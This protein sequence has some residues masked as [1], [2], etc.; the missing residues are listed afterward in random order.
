MKKLSL[1]AATLM[2]FAVA[3][4]QATRA[5]TMNFGDAVALW[6]NACKADVTTK[7]KGIRVGGNRLGQCIQS[8]ASQRCKE[9]TALFNANMEA[10]FQAQKD[11]PR[12]CASSVKRLCSNFKPGSAR[13]LRCMMRPANFRAANVPCKNAL[14]NA[15]WLDEISIRRN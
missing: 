5:E 12:L 13:V 1:F 9:A 15:G 6:A 4:L 11:A 8:K 10:R 7:C 14:S 2:V 3:S